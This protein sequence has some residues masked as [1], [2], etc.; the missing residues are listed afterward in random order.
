MLCCWPG[1]Y[2]KWTSLGEAMVFLLRDTRQVT[3]WTAMIW[4]MLYLYCVHCQLIVVLFSFWPSPDLCEWWDQTGRAKPL[5]GKGKETDSILGTLK[6]F[7][8]STFGHLG[9]FLKRLLS[10]QF[11]SFRLKPNFWK[12][13]IRTFESVKG[14]KVWRKS[15]HPSLLCVC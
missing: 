9:I 12:L 3:A 15:T 7:R 4:G 1:R 6:I 10:S 5:H 14:Y 13:S 8:I 11:F 2:R